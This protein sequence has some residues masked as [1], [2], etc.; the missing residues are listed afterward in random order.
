MVMEKSWNMKNWPKVMEFCDHSWNFTNFPKEL[1]QICMFLVATK[2]LINNLES[3]HFP[4]FSAKCRE[5]GRKIVME[6]QEMVMEK[7]WKNILSSLWE[8][9]YIGR[10]VG[11]PLKNG[12]G[13]SFLM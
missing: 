7:S 11:R 2:K 5:S 6:N 10:A 8:P 1:Y 9:C 12:G 13:G 4:K 3:P